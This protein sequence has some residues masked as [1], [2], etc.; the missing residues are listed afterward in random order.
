LPIPVQTAFTDIANGTQ[1]SKPGAWASAL[2]VGNRVIVCIAL[3]GSTNNPS[4]T[5]SSINV[6][7]DTLSL[8]PGATKSQGSGSTGTRVEVWTGTIVTSG[9]VALVVNVSTAANIEAVAAEYP[10][11]TYTITLDGSPVTNSGGSGTNPSSGNLSTTNASD[12]LIFAVGVDASVS[13]A[14]ATGPTGGFASEISHGL[15]GGGTGKNS[16]GPETAI[17]NDQAVS[18]MGTYSSGGTISGTPAWATVILAFKQVAQVSGPQPY[19]RTRA[20]L[21]M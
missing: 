6:G 13:P 15:N 2:T 19:R 1:A 21:A 10:G 20:Y 18:T 4:P 12:L 8:V 17:L 5:V 3:S 11:G 9:Q 7:T 16:T 14:W